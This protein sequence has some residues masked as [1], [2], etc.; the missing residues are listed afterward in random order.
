MFMLSF[1][2]NSSPWK[3]F[4]CFYWLQEKFADSSSQN[5]LSPLVCLRF[6]VPHVV[7]DAVLELVQD[8]GFDDLDLALVNVRDVAVRL[9]ACYQ[10]LLIFTSAKVLLRLFFACCKHR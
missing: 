8:G 1:L 5:L 6:F 3:L 9:G 4:G 10:P 7:Y 2:A